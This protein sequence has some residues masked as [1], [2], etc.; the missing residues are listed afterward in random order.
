M[1]EKKAGDGAVVDLKNLK[2]RHRSA[3]MASGFLLSAANGAFV[4]SN[5]SFPLYSSRFCLQSSSTPVWW[6]DCADGQM[7]YMYASSR[8]CREIADQ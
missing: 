1:V 4:R 8:N 5:P 6:I 2:S 7:F 3:I